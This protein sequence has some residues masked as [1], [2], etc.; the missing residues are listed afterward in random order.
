MRKEQ[1]KQPKATNCDFCLYF[2]EDE[3]TG[4]AV[5]H[6]ALDEDEM[7]Y[8]MKGKFQ[9]CPISDSTTNTASSKNK[10]KN[11]LFPQNGSRAAHGS[12]KI[13]LLFY[14]SISEYSFSPKPSAAAASMVCAPLRDSMRSM[15]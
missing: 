15:R 12:R 4:L 8:F 1:K 7:L 13:C 2:H 3:D 6:M 14:S 11:Q 10:C 9:N 5:C